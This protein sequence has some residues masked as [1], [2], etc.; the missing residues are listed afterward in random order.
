MFNFNP[1]KLKKDFVQTGIKPFFF[2]RNSWRIPIEPHRIL[3]PLGLLPMQVI[4]FPSWNPATLRDTDAVRAV[5][6]TLLRI[7][8]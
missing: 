6:E 5:N 3:H 4:T 7:Y 8:F 2:F 1:M